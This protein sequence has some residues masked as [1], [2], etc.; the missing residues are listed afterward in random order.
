MLKTLVLA[1][2]KSMACC[3]YHCRLRCRGISGQHAKDHAEDSNTVNSQSDSALRS[4]MCT[5]Q[6][7]ILRVVDGDSVCMK[8]VV[9]FWGALKSSNG[10]D[11]DG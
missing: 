3:L 9:T 6:I 4:P 11:S 7:R 10:S 2:G 5:P 1:K 8:G